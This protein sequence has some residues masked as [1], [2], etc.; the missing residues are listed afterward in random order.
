MSG[1]NLNP[2][3]LNAGATKPINLSALSY[4][5]VYLLIIQ[6]FMRKRGKA[7]K[8]GNVVTSEWLPVF[9]SPFVTH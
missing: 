1:M 7:P 3:L 2:L 4:T 8:I 5:T 9:L 6:T